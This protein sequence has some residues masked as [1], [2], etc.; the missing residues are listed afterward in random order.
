MRHALVLALAL[1]AFACGSSEDP[2]GTT[3]SPATTSGSPTSSN[4]SSGAGGN[5]GSSSNGG[6]GGAPDFQ[7]ETKY[8]RQ[9]INYANV[10][11]TNDVP[12]LWIEAAGIDA[13]PPGGPLPDGTLIVREE[14]DPVVNWVFFRHKVNG[15]WVQGNF[16]P[17]DMTFPFTE[18]SDAQDGCP[19]CHGTAEDTIFSIH[20][21]RRFT[22]T[23]VAESPSC[24]QPGNT[25][26]PPQTYY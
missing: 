8:G 5:G 9:L 4:A 25:P 21:L 11:K 18:Y 15:Q 22:G 16:D 3:T 26:C 12:K 13:V 20:I 6:S 14:G 23:A 17:T 1:F 19:A 7:I 24:N 2:D 10:G